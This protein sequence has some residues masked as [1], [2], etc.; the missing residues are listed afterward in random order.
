MPCRTSIS[1]PKWE[2]A[3]GGEGKEKEEE[4]EEMMKEK[5]N[6]RTNERMNFILKRLQIRH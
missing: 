6:E 4:E 2:E 5:N 1:S 3:D